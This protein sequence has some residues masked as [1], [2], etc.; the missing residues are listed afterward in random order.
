MRCIR[1]NRTCSGYED[2]S[3]EAPSQHKAVDLT[4]KTS[5]LTS[6]RRCSIPIRTLIPGTDILP[7]D[8]SPPEATEAQSNNFALRGFIYDFC[9]VTGNAKLSRGY[10]S[11]IENLVRRLGPKSDLVKACQA[12]DMACHALPLHRPRF[13]KRA[14]T[15]YQQLLGSLARTIDK[16]KPSHPSEVKFV[17]MLLGLY[18][19]L[20]LIFSM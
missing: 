13:M 6:P 14:E 9:L 1:A 18:E 16:P 2:N 5:F 3:F 12:V 8:V 15:F 4:D 19:V 11:G 7:P 20:A 10:L 17:A